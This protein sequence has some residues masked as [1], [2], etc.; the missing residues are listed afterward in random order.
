MKVSSLIIVAI[1]MSSLN[2]VHGGSK[3]D[4]KKIL[5]K[6]DSYLGFKIEDIGIISFDAYRTSNFTANESYIPL[7]YNAI[8]QSKATKGSL[9]KSTGIFSAPIEGAYQFSMMALPVLIGDDSRAE[10]C[11]L[12]MLH[13]GVIVS[14]AFNENP[15]FENPDVDY[16]R[17]TVTGNAI[18]YLQ[19][20]DQVWV[21]TY[22][23]LFA[24]VDNPMIHFIGSLLHPGV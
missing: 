6:I 15:D 3:K 18:L 16:L 11:Y 2:I 23:S 14:K 17:A 5:K 19:V 7:T 22:L 10:R 13:N 20:G 8:R 9:K 21:E 12:Q 4:G 1:I 24:N